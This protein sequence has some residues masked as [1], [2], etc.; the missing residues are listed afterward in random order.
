LAQLLGEPIR[1]DWERVDLDA[2]DRLALKSYNAAVP[3]Q[4]SIFCMLELRRAH[5]IDPARVERIE[6]DVFEDA[7]D[8]MGGGRF[9]PKTDVHTKEDA[10]HSLPYLLAVAVL[11]GDVQPAQ[12]TPKRI[13]KPDVQGLL[14]KVKV[15]PNDGFTA[16]YP[17]EVPS[18]VT[19]RL[20]GGKSYS[21][22]VKDYPGFATRPFTWEESVKKFDKL[23]AGRADE[24]LGRE[25]K[26]AVRSLEDIQ[27]RDLMKLLSRVKAG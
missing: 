4:S 13:E 21:H 12:L 10:D 25:I 3:G 27:V 26:D 23:V 9:G 19:V 24:G 2:F 20:K 18:R 17:G 6:N 5:A 15:K 7:Y 8:F 14:R 16:L 11:D 1:I 22:E